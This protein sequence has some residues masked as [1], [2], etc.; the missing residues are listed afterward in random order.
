[1][2]RRGISR[3][4]IVVIL[5]AVLVLLCLAGAIW[6]FELPF[7]LAVG[8][9]PFLGSIG[10]R[11]T[12]DWNVIATG[13]GALFTFTVGLHWF[14]SWVYSGVVATPSASG[15]SAAPLMQRP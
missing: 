6:P 11:M 3:A 10:S 15:E 9:V 4:A 8:W 12:P 1:M 2:K 7:W 14:L 5:V 13:F